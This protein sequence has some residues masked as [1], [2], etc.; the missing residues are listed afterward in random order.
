MA[1]SGNT[2][3]RPANLVEYRKKR[4]KKHLLLK[5]AALILILIVILII[6][7]N[8]SNIIEPLQG[9]TSRIDSKTSDDVGFP[10]KLPGSASYSFD[11]F[12]DN[13]ILLTD[14]YLY[15]FG[16]DGGQNY[17]VRHGYTNPVQCTNSKRIL[18]YDKDYNNFSLYSKTSVIYSK[19]S[20]EK[21]VAASLG[22]NGSTAIITSSDRYS[23]IIYIYDEKGEWA[24]TRKFVDENVM[25][26][27]FSSDERYIYVDTIGVDNG[28]I[29]SAVYKFD[30]RTEDE[31]LWKYKMSK[32]GIPFA[33][34][35]SD[36]KVKIIYDCFIISLNETDGSLV[37]EKDFL[38]EVECFDFSDEITVMV[39]T[40]LSTNKQIMIAL[41][42]DMNTV[43]SKT[44]NL[45]IKRAVIDDDKIYVIES[46]VLRGYDFEGEA[47]VEKTLNDEYV[48]FIKIGDSVLL[49]GYSSVD[50]KK[51]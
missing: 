11:A 49:L 43:F 16:M 18:I 37:G 51:L 38:G 22:D 45:N 50:L 6:A 2:D 32:S 17:A 31:A 3:K 41:D 9:L 14:T 23:N 29:Y 44:V 28:E 20:D 34:N 19:T 21:I 35:V 36:G 13:F 5:L 15:T 1:G 4:K 47:A 12:G 24:Y 8:F 42:P 46:G 33:M 48:S 7:L 10:I 39:Y 40:D 26:V 27:Q 25:N 30:T